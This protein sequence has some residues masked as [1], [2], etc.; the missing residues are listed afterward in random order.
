MRLV[1][2]I[3]FGAALGAAELP[4]VPDPYDLGERLALIDHLQD[5]YG[6][7]P[8]AGAT[9]GDLQELYARTWQAR[10]PTTDPGQA[11]RVAR[12]RA[13]IL[14][15]HDTQAGP[16]LDEEALKA[17]LVQLDSERAEADRR[18]IAERVAVDQATPRADPN[19]RAAEPAQA[20]SVDQ[21]APRSQPPA[22]VPAPAKPGEIRRIPFSASGVTDCWLAVS[23]ERTALLVTFGLDHNGAFTGVREGVWT[24]L[25]QSPTVS[26]SVLLLGHGR[27]AEIAG[28]SISAHLQ[29]NKP[30]YETMG[31]TAPS[32]PVACL[33]LAACADGV[34]AGQMPQMRDGLGYYPLWRVAT[35][36]GDSANILT[37]LAA[38]DDVVKRPAAPAY[39]A[40]Y[41]IREGG[42]EVT[43]FGEIGEGSRGAA[44]YWRIVRDDARGWRIEEQR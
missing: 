39:R 19:E 26:R 5:A 31:G 41:R 37:V 40:R 30:F 43:S 16:G 23:G 11:E 17:L 14:A 33:I 25:R 29:K 38:L 6:V 36:E 24:I 21:P 2:A 3:L 28:E 10:Q 22:K 4:P 32:Q 1:I 8:P 9:L 20:L 18:V 34:G 42:E 44:T 12:L 15:R 27:K 35:G 13:R 7:R